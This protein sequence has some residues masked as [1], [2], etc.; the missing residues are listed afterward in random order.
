VP[1]TDTPTTTAPSTDTPTTT[2]PSTVTQTVTVTPQRTF[3]PLP[4]GQ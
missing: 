2:A 3:F 1:T 4:G